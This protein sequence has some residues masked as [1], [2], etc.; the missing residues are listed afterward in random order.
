M[1]NFDW[2][3]SLSNQQLADYILSVYKTGV[4]VGKDKIK[5]PKEQFVD[6]EK[7]LV[8]ERQGE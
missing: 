8:E 5:I 4:I 3:K 7:W 2:I 6:Y 1:T